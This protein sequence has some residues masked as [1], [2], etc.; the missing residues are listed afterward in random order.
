MNGV[1][2]S[3]WV[4]RIP[5][6]K[7]TLGISEGR[8]GLALLA[9]GLGALLSLLI[10]GWLVVRYGSKPVTT[11]AAITVCL[12]L[13]LPALA[14]TWLTLA[15]ALFVFG[16][17]NG[18]L[19]VSMNSQG[20]LIQRRYGRPILSSMHAAFSFGGFSGAVTG[21]LI[22]AAG[23]S[24]AVHLS[25][26][27]IVLAIAVASLANRLLSADQDAQKGGSSFARPSRA[28]AALGIVAFCG[29]LIEGA[30]A[31]WSAVYM[32]DTLNTGPGL[33]AGGFA[34]FSL[35]MAIGRLTGD[36]L[37]YL[38]NPVTV[39][40]YG[41]GFAAVGMGLTL[42][43]P[44]PLLAI[45]GFGLVGAGMANVVP[46]IFSAAGRMPGIS[47]GPAIAA[48]ATTGYFGFLAGPPVIGLIAE[49]ITLRVALSILVLLAATSA[50]LAGSVR[51]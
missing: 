36:R 41:G 3:S 46:I 47:P 44:H 43:A 22:A 26:V 11:I 27:G 12:L 31:D 48:V 1:L 18:A 21:G 45:A 9:L 24:P 42:A 23:I 37:V 32:N 13:P 33:A 51:R 14:P 35:T 38:S 8:L 40:R 17:G 15:L 28:L 7:D 30:I 6:V 29:L 39:A 4:T 34:A 10:A 2:F 20:V 16:A 19:D 50:I 25:G 5:Q 49:L